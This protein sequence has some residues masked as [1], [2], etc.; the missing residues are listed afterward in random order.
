M[1][2]ACAG[3]Q[4]G[5]GSGAGGGCDRLIRNSG[6]Q[7]SRANCGGGSS[8]RRHR[9]YPCEH[10]CETAHLSLS[11]AIDDPQC[12]LIVDSDNSGTAMRSLGQSLPTIWASSERT[13]ASQLCFACI[14]QANCVCL[15]SLHIAGCIFRLVCFE[16]TGSAMM[17]QACAAG[18][19]T[20]GADWQ[21][22][23]CAVACGHSRTHSA[24]A[25]SDLL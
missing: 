24:R 8:C 4:S 13:T 20:G 16:L 10:P 6:C 18:G 15:F 9:R 7:L 23:G 1:G 3:G 17:S 2:I 25:A 11:A 12:C 14:A 19:G 21:W 22:S 5:R